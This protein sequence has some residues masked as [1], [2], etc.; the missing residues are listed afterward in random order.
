MTNV[1]D[2]QK[3]RRP[4]RM[5][6]E[7]EQIATTSGDAPA[8]T[9]APRITKASIVE[10][11]LLRHGGATLDELCQATGWQAHTCRA[12]LTGLRKKGHDLEKAR[13]E[14]GTTRWSIVSAEPA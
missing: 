11:L 2:A 7:P 14:D 13:G 10:V 12:F 6:R 9:L 3:S 8:L 5:A 4:R 1:N